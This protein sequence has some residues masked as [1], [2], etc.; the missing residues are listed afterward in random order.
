[1]LLLNLYQFACPI[2][3]LPLNTEILY[4]ITF[5]QFFFLETFITY[6]LP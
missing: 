5:V 1:M 3:S 2:L 6:L 4:V